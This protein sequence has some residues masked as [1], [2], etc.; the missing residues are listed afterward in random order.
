MG[1]DFVCMK[2]ADPKSRHVRE[3]GKAFMTASGG[4]LV[5]AF[6]SRNKRSP[7]CGAAPIEAAFRI[8]P[9]LLE[10]TLTNQR[11]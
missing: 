10:K 5:S 9:G 6:L 2:R 1:G 11:S 3:W 7:Q 8:P 4:N